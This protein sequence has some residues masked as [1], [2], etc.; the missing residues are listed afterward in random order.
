[1]GI[2]DLVGNNISCADMILHNGTECL[3]DL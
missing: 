3:D 1:L 2:L